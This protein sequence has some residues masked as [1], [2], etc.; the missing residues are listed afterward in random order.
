MRGKKQADPR[1]PEEWAWLY[2]L[3]VEHNQ[4]LHSIH[5][6]L[7][8]VALLVLLAVIVAGCGYVARL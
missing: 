6:V 3:L 1:V 8:I 2:G 7:Q 5:V 4:T